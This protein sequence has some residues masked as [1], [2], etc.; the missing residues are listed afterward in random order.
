MTDAPLFKDPIVA[1]MHGPVVESV[2]HQYKSNGANGIQFDED[3]NFDSFTEDENELLRMVYDVFGQYSAW[4]LRN[5]TH[6]EK[7][8]IVT[9]QNGEI[10]QDVIKDFFKREYIEQ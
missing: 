9:Q 10:S 2:Y 3:F 1:W 7:P 6:G 8:W 4:K 5:M